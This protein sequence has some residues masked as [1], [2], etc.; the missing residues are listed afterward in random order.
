MLFLVKKC[1]FFDVFYIQKCDFLLY[2]QLQKCDSRQW[3][4]LKEK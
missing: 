2:L 3:N 1:D 4:Y